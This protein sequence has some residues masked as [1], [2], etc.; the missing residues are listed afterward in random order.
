MRDDSRCH[1]YLSQTGTLIADRHMHWGL[2][3]LDMKISPK[4]VWRCRGGAALLDMQQ[5]RFVLWRMDGVAT[6]HTRVLLEY[7][8]CV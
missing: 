1:N 3:I 7:A 4:E 8:R 6:V 5:E 2:S